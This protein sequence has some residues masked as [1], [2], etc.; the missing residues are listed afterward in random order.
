MQWRVRGGRRP[1]SRERAD[2]RERERDP[3][4]FFFFFFFR[5]PPSSPL[6]APSPCALPARRRRSLRL[7]CLF[8]S[9]IQLPSLRK[10]APERSLRGGEKA[11]REKKGSKKKQ[12]Q[13]GKNGDRLD[14]VAAFF[15]FFFFFNLDRRDKQQQQQE[16]QR[17]RGRNLLRLPAGFR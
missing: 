4:F 17:P 11:Q 14:D 2:S 13:R 10:P 5:I 3:L 15:V 8:A 12:K 1:R 6:R 16:Q 9:E 7:A